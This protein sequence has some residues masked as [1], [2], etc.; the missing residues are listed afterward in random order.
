MFSPS[1]FTFLDQLN[2]NNNRQWFEANRGSD[3]STV[4]QSA[5][6]GERLVPPPRGDAADHPALADLPRNDLVAVGPLTRTELLAPDVI[7]TVASRFCIV[8]EPGPAI[9][10][11]RTTTAK[12][13]HHEQLQTRPDCPR[14]GHRHAAGLRRDD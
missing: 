1:T 4:R 10:I 14:R 9:A 2:D 7:Q 6:A 3:E 5:L 8:G 13:S 11:I 12:R